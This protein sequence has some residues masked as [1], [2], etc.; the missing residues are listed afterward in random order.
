MVHRLLPHEVTVWHVVRENGEEG[1]V[2][3]T[4]GPVRFCSET[5]EKDGVLWREGILYLFPHEVK[6]GRETVALLTT[7]DY[8]APGRIEEEDVTKVAECY[9]VVRIGNT[10]GGSRCSFL[11]IDCIGG[12]EELG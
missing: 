9:R 1:L 7:G 3:R 5:F 2:R 6:N 11:R 12:G 10:A 4:V 8:L